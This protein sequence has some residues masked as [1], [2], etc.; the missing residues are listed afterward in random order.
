MEA[1]RRNQRGIGGAKGKSCRKIAR[2]R[3]RE[4]RKGKRKRKI[5]GKEPF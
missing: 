5:E 3:K 4:E 2:D 1:R